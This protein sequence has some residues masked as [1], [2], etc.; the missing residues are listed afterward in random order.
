M[1]IQVKPGHLYRKAKKFYRKPL[2]ELGKRG[3]KPETPNKP[4]DPK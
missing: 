1:K 2:P 3:K 4:E